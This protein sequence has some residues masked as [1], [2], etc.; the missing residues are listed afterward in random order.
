MINKLNPIL[1]PYIKQPSTWIKNIKWRMPAT[2]SDLDVVFVMGCPR[3]GTTLIQKVIEG[4]DNYFS[5]QGETGLF[6]YQNIFDINREHFG[7]SA[8]TQKLMF[9]MSNDIVDFFDRSVR[10]IAKENNNRIFIEKTPQHVIH[11]N[12]LIRYFPNAKFVNIVRD[13]R[14]CFGSA[15]HHRNIP[16][17]KSAKMFARYWKKCVL[18]PWRHKDNSN[19]YTLKY[20]EFTETPYPELEKLMIFLGCHMMEKQL[21]P[22]SYGND[23]RANSENF[24]RLNEK[25]NT[26]SVARWRKELDKDEKSTFLRIAGHELKAY[27]Y[28]LAG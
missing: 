19:L 18:P 4:H 8:G 28:T 24:K 7:L 16:Q 26:S 2:V 15:K 12:K 22:E 13:G 25:I 5:I 17:S 11:L 6:S 10:L 9:N 3:S 23:K 21:D 1:I 27:G 20:E 14:D